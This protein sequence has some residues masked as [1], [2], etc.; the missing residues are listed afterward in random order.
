MAVASISLPQ[1]L[2]VKL[3]EKAEEAGYLPEEFGV[4]LIR[5]SLDEELDPEDLVEHYQSLSEKYL[6]EARKLLKEGDLVQASEKFWG[7]SALAVKRI[8]A[9]KGLKLEEHGGLWSFVN[10]LAMQSGDKELTTFFHVANSLHRNFYEDEMKR[11]TVEI[12]AEN[13]EKLVDKLRGIS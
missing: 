7:A 12:A 11:E 2:G 8:A 9:K 10:V 4:E 3:R 5:K 1:K 13:I 6:R